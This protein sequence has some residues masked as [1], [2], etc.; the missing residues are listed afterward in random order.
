MLRSILLLT[1]GLLATAS[2]TEA[3]SPSLSAVEVIQVS[4]QTLPRRAELSGQLSAAQNAAL[5]PRL[6]GVIESIEVDAGAQVDKGQRLLKLDDR[7]ARLDLASAEAASKA[8]AVRLADAERI[9]RESVPLAERG[10]LPASQL[11]GVRAALEVARA[12]YREQQARSALIREQL[13]RHWLVAPFAGVVVERWV[14]VG[15][16]VQASDPVLTLV[17]DAELRFDARAP[18][19][20][21]GRLDPEAPITLRIDGRETPLEGARIAAQVPASDP[22]SRSFLLRLAVPAQQPALL[23]GASGRVEIGLR[24]ERSAFAVPRS[25]LVS[26]PDGGRA[27]WLAVDEG[28]ATVARSVRVQLD[29][30]VADPALVVGGLSGG[31]RVI[32]RGQT[33]LRD[34]EALQIV[35]ES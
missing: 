27:L 31:E 8:A 10:L 24:G 20:W 17:S 34:G 15:E 14:D 35:A 7:L 1:T 5:S 26:Y 32:V 16:W 29:G 4:Q 28:G 23:P 22:A 25:A 12:E 33:R 2:V 19:E 9:E 13:E 3:Q 11:D 18:Q 6:A 21:F 30:S